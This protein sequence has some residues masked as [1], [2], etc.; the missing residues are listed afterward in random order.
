MQWQQIKA[1]AGS[2]TASPQLFKPP[3]LEAMEVT[4][5]ADRNACGFSRSSRFGSLMANLPEP[6]DYLIVT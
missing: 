4:Y 5:S 1:S 3:P 2:L 6:G